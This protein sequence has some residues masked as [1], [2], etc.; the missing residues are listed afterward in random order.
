MNA[1]R[2]GAAAAAA[3][4]ASG[5]SPDEVCQLSAM[6]VEELGQEYAKSAASSPTR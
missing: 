3:A 4:A 5:G 1:K 2:G 6:Y